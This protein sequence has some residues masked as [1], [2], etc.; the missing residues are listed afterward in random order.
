M[1]KKDLIISCIA[2]VLLFA[3]LVS[4]VLKNTELAII[5]SNLGL[6]LLA[7]SYLWLHKQ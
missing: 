4:W 7:I 3:S 2:I 5:T 1:Q 6:A